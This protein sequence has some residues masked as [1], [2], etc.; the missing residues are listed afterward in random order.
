M[1]LICFRSRNRQKTHMKLKA[2]FKNS[3]YSFYLH[4]TVVSH[5]I[6]FAHKF[7]AVEMDWITFEKQ[8][9]FYSQ[10]TARCLTNHLGVLQY[11]NLHL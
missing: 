3:V 10:R 1:L 6:F 9:Q 5:L 8:K 11:F 4:R 7:E 2:L